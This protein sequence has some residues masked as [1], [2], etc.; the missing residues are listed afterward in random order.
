MSSAE[1]ILESDK[2]TESQEPEKWDLEIK[3]QGHL[4]DINF[5]DI[6]RY[7]DLLRMFVKRDVVTVYK[8]TVLGPIWFIVQPILTTAIYILVF[9][10]IANISTDGL[11]QVLF[12]L[13]GIVIWN[14][15]SE[16]FNSTSQTFTQN[17]GIFGKVY[18]PR[19]IMPLSKITSGLI[20]F[21]IQFAFF[22]AIFA[23]FLISGS[24]I[25]PNINMLLIP[26]YVLLMA[27]LGLGF[28]IIF[29]SLTSK[30]R[31]LTFLISF[32]VQLL[33]YAT[34]VI[35]PVSTIPDKYKPLIMANPMTPIVEGFRYAMLGTGTFDWWHLAYSGG[36]MLVTLFIGIIIFNK[37]EKTFMDTV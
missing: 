31:D 7:R 37:V 3:P 26:V 22:L 12:Y 28:G 35:Y 33:M 6:W 21:G 24:D 13:S 29:T 5:R 10:N 30:Y 1:I 15:F 32:G 27:G 2:K 8:Q 16:S 4:L 18:F 14:Y 17:A 11:P 34:P 20:K 9:G 23:Y 19:L 25:N 36:F